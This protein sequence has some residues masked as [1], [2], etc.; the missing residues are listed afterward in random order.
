MTQN[1]MW[2]KQAGLALALGIGSLALGQGG[3]VERLKSEL[4]AKNVQIKEVQAELAKLK[5]QV[6]Q[7]NAQLKSNQQASNLTARLGELPGLLETDR[8]LLLEL[9]KNLPEGRGEAETYL[10]RLQALALKSDPARFGNLVRRVKDSAPS[11]LNWRDKQFET[12]EE[13]AQAFVQSGAQAFRGAFSNF[14]EAVL[15]SVVNHIESLL[16]VLDR[17]K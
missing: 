14:N 10:E 13:A 11:F 8:A 5:T 15:L 2:L 6:D 12:Q 1:S 9:R 16:D 4:E 3:E 7:L 17:L